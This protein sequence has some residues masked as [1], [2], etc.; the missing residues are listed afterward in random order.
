MHYI[1]EGINM[2][3]KWFIVELDID[4]RFNVAELEHM[5][6]E[7]LDNHCDFNYL[8]LNVRE[9]NPDDYR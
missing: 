1:I 8:E 9:L 4:K 2:V 7:E 3:L 5:I 6:G